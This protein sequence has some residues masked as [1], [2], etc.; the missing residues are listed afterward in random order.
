MQLLNL[1]NKLRHAKEELNKIINTK[2]F[3][4]GN[5]LIY[6]LDMSTRQLRLMKDNVF[7]L[8]KTLKETMR[9]YFDKDLQQTRTLLAEQKRKFK[10]YQLTLNSYMRENVTE[11]IN[12]I[13]EV[14]KKRVEAYKDVHNEQDTL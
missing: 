10:E 1:E 11:N 14:M 12:Y 8:E 13:D 5:N 9:L 7:G 6:E 2:V 4:R 3:S